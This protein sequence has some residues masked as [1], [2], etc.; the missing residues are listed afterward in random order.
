MV[1]RQTSWQLSLCGL[2][3]LVGT[4]LASGLNA[5]IRDGIVCV[6]LD[7]T[8]MFVDWLHRAIS[9]VH[10]RHAWQVVAGISTEKK[11]NYQPK[12][13]MDSMGMASMTWTK[14]VNRWG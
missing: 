5:E 8:E 3:T 11:P 6:G 13:V 2:S 14:F 7:P 12:P 9:G 10:T 4:G 1:T